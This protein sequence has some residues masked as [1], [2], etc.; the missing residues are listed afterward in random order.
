MAVTTTRN[1][2]AA[3]VT[4]DWPDRRNAIGPDGAAQLTDALG[5]AAEDRDVCAV[6]LTGSGGTF[7]AG[8][9]VPDLVRAASDGPDAVRSVVYGAFQ[10]VIRAVITVPVPV[11]AAIDGPAVGF[12]MD[13][14]L[15]CDDRFIG[16][17][18]QLLQRWAGLGLIPGT[19]GELLL[20]RR[21]P[22]L[23]WQIVE[24]QQ[25]IDAAAAAAHGLGRRASPTGLDA[26]VRAA[27]SLSRRG[28][29]TL[30]AYCA[31][32]RADLAAT[33]ESHLEACVDL[34]VALADDGAAARVD[35]ALRQRKHSPTTLEQA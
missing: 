5:R 4:L 23:L 28:R 10:A 18:G 1:G 8:G 15:A 27:A 11:L 34:Q 16:P 30:E 2:P 35:A 17:R 31:L 29:A 21:S 20:R 7:C 33:L 26:A 14:A 12:G 3:I 24:E 13:L 9:N 22:S 32:S 19:G 6:V 25:P